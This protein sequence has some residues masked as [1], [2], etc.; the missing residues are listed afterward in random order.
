M[1]AL[2]LAWGM[3]TLI[4]LVV[5]I[6]ALWEAW[7][8]KREL[9]KSGRNGALLLLAKALVLQEAIASSMLALLFIVSLASLVGVQ[10][11]IRRQIAIAGLSAVALLVVA[12]V[13]ART[14]TR[15]QLMTMRASTH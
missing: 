12:Q 10:V 11:D 15:R 6:Y 14:Y 9:I 3:V 1:S 4:G 7:L 8:D 5:A 13:V 2:L